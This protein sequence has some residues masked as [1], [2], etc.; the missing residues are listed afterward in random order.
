[1]DVL[2]SM[3]LFF[4]LGAFVRFRA[5]HPRSLRWANDSFALAG[6]MP[7]GAGGRWRACF[8]PGRR[9]P[10]VNG[11]RFGVGSRCFFFAFYSSKR[12]LQRSNYVFRWMAMMPYFG[13]AMMAFFTSL[14]KSNAV[15]MLC[16]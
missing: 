6:N 9:T 4:V 2:V 8:D 3:E 5:V 16:C 1:M 15:L 11:G 10:V 14:L 12:T 13:F 7:M